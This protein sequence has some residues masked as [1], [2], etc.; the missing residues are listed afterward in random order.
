MTAKVKGY[1]AG[2]RSKFAKPFRRS[3]AIRMKNY[4][5]KHKVGEYVDIIVDG[6]IH[7]GMPHHF[8]HG[9]TGRIF[10]VA[11][12][13]L[14]VSILKQVRNRREE[15]RLNI[16]IEHLRKSDCRTKFLDVVRQNDALRTESNK[17]NKVKLNLKRV[18][19]LPQV[20]K[21]VAFDLT[22]LKVTNALP[23]MVIH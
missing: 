9:R 4:L 6:A 17:T 14:G 11:P 20:A 23:Y 19:Q 22:S 12:R 21:T 13:S 8:Y 18:P 1:R 15:K 16:R 2:T 10:N 7:R 3:G 5:Q